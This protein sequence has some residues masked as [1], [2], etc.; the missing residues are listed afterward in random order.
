[1]PEHAAALNQ[2]HGSPLEEAR[3]PTW[4]QPKRAER[5]HFVRRVEHP[6]AK[7]HR[8]GTHVGR[9]GVLALL[10]VHLCRGRTEVHPI[11]NLSLVGF[12]VSILAKPSGVQRAARR[13]R[14]VSKADL[15][16]VS[17]A[18][19]HRLHSVPKVRKVSVCALLL[20]CNESIPG[21]AAH[22]VST[23]ASNVQNSEVGDIPFYADHETRRKGQGN[24]EQRPLRHF[25]EPHLGQ[26]FLHSG[27]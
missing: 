7:L 14:G 9:F 20:F 24:T 5:A 10:A 8:P 27:D 21:G 4:L 3:N 16:H 26:E 23:L 18:R 6:A 19:G 15:I 12:C 2:R 1:M 22:S 25:V 13:M 11:Q 17:G